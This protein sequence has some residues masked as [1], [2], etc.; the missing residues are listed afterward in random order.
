MSPVS[1]VILWIDRLGAVRVMTTDQ[2]TIGGPKPGE[3]SDYQSVQ[4]GISQQACQLSLTS[5]GWNLSTQTGSGGDSDS[6]YLV[7]ESTQVSL[8][9]GVRVA[10][11]KPMQ[12]MQS[13]CLKV[14]STHRTDPKIDF[15]I[16][17]PDFAFLSSTEDAHVVFPG[18]S[19]TLMLVNRGGEI[20]YRVTEND[21]ALWSNSTDPLKPMTGETQ[22]DLDD[23]RL[24]CE[25][26]ALSSRHS[27]TS[28]Q[29]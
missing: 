16:L 15:L 23:Y 24:S 2:L 4:A 25:P 9:S 17:L 6:S 26:L 12:L 13:V 7:T 29:G 22:L 27:Y 3:K 11:N 18:L 28:P 10:V 19:T 14:I 20:W 21:R 1:D 8:G 5:I